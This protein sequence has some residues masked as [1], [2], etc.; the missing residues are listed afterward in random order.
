[1]ILLE[2]IQLILLSLR[3]VLHFLNVPRDTSIIGHTLISAS[4]KSQRILGSWKFAILLGRAMQYVEDA[5]FRTT[6]LDLQ[7]LKINQEI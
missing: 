2:K 5:R 7:A 4:K 3:L 1:V 6:E